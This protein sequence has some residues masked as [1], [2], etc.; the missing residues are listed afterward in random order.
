MSAKPFSG[1]YRESKPILSRF[2]FN[3]DEIDTEDKVAD[4]CREISQ[5][6]IYLTGTYKDWVKIG[7]ALS[8]LGESSRRWFHLCSSQNDGYNAKEC[9][10][11]FNNLLRSNRRIGIGTFFHYCKNAGLDI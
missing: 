1:I 2:N 3:H 6:H 7:A 4:L 11:K 5:R 8:S 9:Y 10:H